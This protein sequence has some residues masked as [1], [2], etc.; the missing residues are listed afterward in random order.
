MKFNKLVGYGRNKELETCYWKGVNG[1]ARSYTVEEALHSVDE[2]SGI[3]Q[4]VSFL[5]EMLSKVMEQLPEEKVLAI[6]NDKAFGEEFILE[7]KG[8]PIER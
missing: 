8:E 5:Y 2:S 7:K 3:E 4:R 1:E 6:L